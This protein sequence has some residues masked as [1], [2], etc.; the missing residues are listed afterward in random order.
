MQVVTECARGL[1]HL[2][3]LQK[4]AKYLRMWVAPAPPQWASNAM[5]AL[6]CLGEPLDA[7]TAREAAVHII[8]R[9]LNIVQVRP[10][11]VHG[12]ICIMWPLDL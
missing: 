8:C 5:A 7:V 9:Y 6:L 2:T 11:A 4:T 10:Q 3:W 12:V 1:L